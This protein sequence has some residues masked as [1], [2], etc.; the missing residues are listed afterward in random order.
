MI[1]PVG[2]EGLN[3]QKAP[4]SRQKKVVSDLIDMNT[5]G[6]E[7][8]LFDTTYRI[9]IEDITWVPQ[10]VGS[11]VTTDGTII[12][13][14]AGDTNAI[15]ESTSIVDTTAVGTGQTL[16]LADTEKDKSGFAAG[17]PVLEVGVGMYATYAAGSAGTD[18]TGKLF[19][20]YSE[21]DPGQ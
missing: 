14:I 4:Q 11:S 10:V 13:G 18:P 1:D 6:V 9:A 3:F 15:V 17:S 21:L 20:T 16:T 12:V 19:V 2:G 7:M 5:S 8:L